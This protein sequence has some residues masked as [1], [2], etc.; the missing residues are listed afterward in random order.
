MVGTNIGAGRA[1][2]ALRTAWIGAAIA[3][4]LAESVGLVAAAFPGQWLGLFDSDPAMIAAGADYLRVV[5][6]CYGFFGLGLALYFASQGAGRLTWPLFAGLGRML[7]ACGG[8]WLALRWRGD[9]THIFLALG[10]ALGAFGLVNAAAVASGA[11]FAAS[12]RPA[13]AAIGAR[14]I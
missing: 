1:E 12:R 6:P 7:I 8:G 9:L 14:R 11:W 3:A 2:R 5:G 4:A 13:L 10:F